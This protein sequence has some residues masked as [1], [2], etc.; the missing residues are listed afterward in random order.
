MRQADL[1]TSKGT[2][3]GSLP[4]SARI[5]SVMTDPST[6]S[7]RAAW[8]IGRLLGRAEAYLPA[9]RPCSYSGAVNPN[10]CVREHT[11]APERCQT[12]AVWG[13]PSAEGRRRVRDAEILRSET[14]GVTDANTGSLRM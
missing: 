9:G 13:R 10:V 2:G 7:G 12:G 14:S 6:G 4:I 5:A 8:V 11:S 3:S 1:S